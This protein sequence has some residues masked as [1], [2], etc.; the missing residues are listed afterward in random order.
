ME[1][2]PS[3]PADNDIIAYNLFIPNKLYKKNMSINFALSSLIINNL[4]SE[5]ISTYMRSGGL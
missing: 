2:E 4:V 5:Q 3:P 1:W